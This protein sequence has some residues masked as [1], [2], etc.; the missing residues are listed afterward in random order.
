MANLTVGNCIVEILTVHVGMLTYFWV[1][2]RHQIMKFLSV[3]Y[4]SSWCVYVNQ[5]IE[6]INQIS[7]NFDTVR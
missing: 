7:H 3:K 1:S 4:V 5:W 2:A 6:W